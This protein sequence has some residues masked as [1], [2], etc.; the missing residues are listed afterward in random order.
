MSRPVKRWIPAAGAGRRRRKKRVCR[1]RRSVVL[2]L[3]KEGRVCIVYCPYKC[4]DLPATKADTNTCWFGWAFLQV[5]NRNLMLAL[6][7]FDPWKFSW[8]GLTNHTLNLFKLSRL[9]TAHWKISSQNIE[10]P[11]AL[12]LFKTAKQIQSRSHSPDWNYIF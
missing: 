5:W 1:K 2:K 9:Y 4:L 7:E 12:K 8:S 11:I 10:S 6:L 3:G